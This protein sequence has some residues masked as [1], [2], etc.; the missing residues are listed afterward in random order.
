MT[1]ARKPR[2]ASA[3]DLTYPADAIDAMRADE[4]ERR[5]NAE[6]TASLA[7]REVQ[8]LKERVRLLETSLASGEVGVPLEQ[9]DTV[10]H[11]IDQAEAEIFDLRVELAH[12]KDPITT[13]CECEGCEQCR[14][15]RS[16]AFWKGECDLDAVIPGGKCLRCYG[17]QDKMDRCRPATTTLPAAQPDRKQYYV[18]TLEDG[19][20][21][22]DS[23]KEAREYAV[24]E[25]ERALQ[26]K[27]HESVGQVEW[28]ELL[29]REFAAEIDRKET[30]GG[31]HDYTCNYVLTP[32]ADR[33]AP[34]ALLP[35][36]YWSVVTHG[37]ATAIFASEEA[38][39]AFSRLE[40]KLAGLLEATNAFVNTNIVEEHTSDCENFKHPSCECDCGF[41]AQDHL[42]RVIA[43]LG[44]Q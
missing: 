6:W 4:E 26:D 7:Q 39:R 38:A 30:P 10:L 5:M 34:A 17:Q 25:I 36:R 32:V 24:G 16:G 44:A 13:S 8:R 20:Q 33:P 14:T 31:E 35:G 41:D 18:C 11:R 3:S 43:D 19:V 21:V 40:Q 22:V 23:E 27:W 12:V 42:L 2:A 15:P 37:G 29:P 9:Y 1:D 28:G